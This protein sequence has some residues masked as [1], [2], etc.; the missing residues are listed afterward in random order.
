M[1]GYLLLVV[2]QFV[3]AFFGAP[4]VLRY[5]PVQGDPAIFVHAAIFAVIVWVVGVLGSFALKDVRMPSTATLASALIG[6]TIGA[7]LMVFAPQLLAAIPLKF[8][9]LYVPLVGA[10]VGYMVRR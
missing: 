9:R 6:A 8:P 5:I 10:I 2:L 4:A 3:A 7:A 1:I